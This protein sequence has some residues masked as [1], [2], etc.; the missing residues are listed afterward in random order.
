MP[1][2]LRVL[3]DNRELLG[4][5]AAREFRA[6][7]GTIG[8][9]RDNDWVLPDEQRYIS[10]R[11]ALLDYQA[12]SYYLVDMS[13]NGVF[14]NG[15]DVAVGRGHPQRLFDGDR[16]RI[17]D[18]EL[19]V[20]ISP[21]TE[22]DLEDG[23]RDSIV[24]AQL[25]PEA[26]ADEPALV[27][28]Q[29]LLE[30]SVMRRHL[31]PS[32]SQRLP[33]IKAREPASPAGEAALKR[34]ASADQRA[35]ARVLEAAGLSPEVLAGSLPSEWLRFAGELLRIAVEGLMET[36]RTEDELRTR[37]GLP[38]GTRPDQRRNPLRFALNVE[39]ALRYLF[40]DRGEAYLPAN[41]AL[42][43]AFGE[44]QIH[45]RALVQA[46]SQAAQHYAAY[47]DPEE[48][49]RN[50]DRGP[51]RSSLLGGI[52]KVRYWDLYAQAYT[53]LARAEQG[54]PPTLFGEELA[55]AYSEAM[56][57]KAKRERQRA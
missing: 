17:G 52:N 15:S 43:G 51:R 20:E 29:K 37:L 3:S 14:V 22:A 49:E 11:H 31:A 35:A 19:A 36:L 44:L 6:H 10:G 23:M 42:K 33:V 7:G 53:D 57:V 39:E 47:F 32:N 40:T 1:L 54:Q 38:Q 24:R 48:L 55:R 50:F 9:A 8:R 5:N 28:E 12:G 16:L 18:F 21:D 25:V 30:D 45:H 34:V 4:D 56:S 2:R 13:R 27:P 26:D 41:E 46:M